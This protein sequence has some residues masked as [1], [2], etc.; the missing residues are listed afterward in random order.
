[1][2]LNNISGGGNSPLCESLESLKGVV[3]EDPVFVGLG[4][5]VRLDR[6]S[7]CKKINICQ[8]R[9]TERSSETDRFC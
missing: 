7:S 1:M 5:T 6:C 9:L 4:L 3:D 2:M 8:S